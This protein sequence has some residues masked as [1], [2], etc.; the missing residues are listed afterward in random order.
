V[1]GSAGELAEVYRA[2]IACLNRRDWATL[3][4]FVDDVVCRNGER[5]GLDGYR[6]MLEGDYAAIPDLR[7]EILTLVSEPP[8]VASRLWFD[9]T[10]I[11]TFLGLPVNGRR[12]SFAENVFYR[13]EGGRIREV[14]SLID[15]E[16]IEARLADR[17]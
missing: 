8:W 13:F 16:G 7:F 4:R 3:G 11:G 6:A 10:P 15:K 1:E 9:C 2:Y 14:W 12:V 17:L 5:L